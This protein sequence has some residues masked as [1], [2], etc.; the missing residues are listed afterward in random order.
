MQAIAAAAF[1]IDGFDLAVDDF[2]RLPRVRGARARA[3][4]GR[5]ESVF[6]HPHRPSGSERVVPRLAGTTLQRGS[7]DELRDLGLA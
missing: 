6:V 7:L 4:L 3:V 2:V 1:A 5:L